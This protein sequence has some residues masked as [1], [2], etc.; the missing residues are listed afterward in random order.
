MTEQAEPNSQFEQSD[1]YFTGG[2]LIGLG[3][4]VL[5]SYLLQNPTL[6]ILILPLLGLGFLV[7]GFYTRRFGFTIPGCILLGLGIPLLLSQAISGLEDT[8]DG[9]VFVLGL[10]FGFA[11]ISVIAPFFKER[12]AWWPLIPGGIL[13]IVGAS[14]LFGDRGLEILRALNFVWPIALVLIG[15]YLLF[16][17]RLRRH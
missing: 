4:L 1:R 7:W 17:P 6:N 13:G 11:A 8:G 9:A 16:S 5:L 15:V 14:M 2:L 3:L 12:R 10:A